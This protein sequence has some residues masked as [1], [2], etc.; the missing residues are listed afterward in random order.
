[1]PVTTRHSG[2]KPDRAQG[3]LDV[4]ELISRTRC[5]ICRG[6]RNEGKQLTRDG[7]KAKPSFLFYFEGDHSTPCYIGQEVVDTGCSRFLIGQKTLEK[8]ERMLTEK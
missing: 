3:R 2:G 1:M 7:E 4:K 8:W 6:N 5:R